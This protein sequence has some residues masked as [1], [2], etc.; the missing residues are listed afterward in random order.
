MQVHKAKAVVRF[1]F[2]N[3][4]DVRWFRPVE[5]WTRSGRRGR[6]REPVR[7]LFRLCALSSAL[8]SYIYTTSVVCHHRATPLQIGTH[9]A[10]KC[11]FDGA[12]RQQDAVL[13]SLYKRAHPVWPEC[14]EFVA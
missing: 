1:M 6:I 14:L 7:G 3:P 13:M 2:H 8:S 10:M 11:V 12:L 9:G 5:L 4:D